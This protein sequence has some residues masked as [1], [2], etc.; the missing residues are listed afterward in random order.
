M[1]FVLTIRFSLNFIEGI[2]II[3]MSAYEDAEVSDDCKQQ[4]R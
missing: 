2:V 1:L 4:G 3:K